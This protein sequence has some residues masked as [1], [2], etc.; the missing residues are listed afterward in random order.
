MS[1]T[2][3]K[4]PAKNSKRRKTKLQ[5]VT[6]GSKPGTLTEELVLHLY[7]NGIRG[8]KV[9][10]SRRGGRN[11]NLER[12]LEMTGSMTGMVGGTEA[13]IG[14]GIGVERGDTGRT[15]SPTR[16]LDCER[17]LGQVFEHRRVVSDPWTSMCQDCG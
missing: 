6:S 14:I 8:N 7:E 10:R 13:V 2:T 11:G 12:Y 9:K 16:A 3:T 1:S 5:P 17:G 4:P 15:R